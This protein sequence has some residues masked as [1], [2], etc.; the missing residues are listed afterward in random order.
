AYEALPEVAEAW[1]VDICKMHALPNDPAL[2]GGQQWYLRNTVL[3][4]KDIRAVGGWAETVGDSNKVIAIVDSGVDW[5]HPDLG[6]SGPDYVNG[7]VWTNWTEYHGSPSVDDDGNGRVDDIR[8][9]DFV[10]VPG[11]GYPDED[12]DTPDNDPMDYESHG[13]ACAGIAA[14]ITNNGVGIA[15]ASHGCK[16]MAVR[17]GW[18][19]NGSDIGVVR[20][21]FASSGISY[22]ADNGADIIN[23][24]WGSTSY[25]SWAVDYAIGE[26][27]IIV[28]S[29]GNDNDE[30]ASY[31]SSRTD[32]L[33]VAATDQ[34]DIKADF[35]SYGNWVE[36]SAPGVSMYTTW[37][38]QTTMSH[39][40]SSVQGTSFSSP[41]TCG[42]LGLIWSAYPAWPA[43]SVRTHIRNTADP[44]DDV[45]PTYAGKLG[46]GRINLLKALGDTFQEI[47]D[48]FEYLL[49]A[50]NEAGDGDTIA[51]LA[52][53]ALSGTQTIIAKEVN[54]LGGYAAGYGSRDPVNTP[55]VITANATQ[56]AINF[57]GNVGNLTV[58]DGFRCVGGGGSVF[59]TPFSGRF[60]GG[61]VCNAASPTLINIDITGNSVGSSSQVGGGG[62]IFLNNSTAILQSCLIHGNSGIFGAG[63]FVYRGSPTFEDCEIYDNT[64]I[65]AN[66]SNPPRG[67]GV[68][69]TDGDPTFT[70][71]RISGHDD[72]IEGGGIYAVNLGLTTNLTLAGN[73]IYDNFAKDNGGGIYMNGTFIS[74]LGDEVHDN[75]KTASATFMNGGG[76]Y[77]T[78]TDADL[79]GVMCYANDAHAHGGGGIFNATTVNVSNSL[80]YGNEASIYV[81]GLSLNTVAGGTISGN[82]IAVNNGA[83][84]GGG[85]LYLLNSTAA[86]TNN[87]VAFNT[88]TGSQACGFFVSGGSPTFFCNDSYN[89]DI[90][91]YGGIA[92]QTGVNGNISADPDFC[93][94]PG[95]DFTIDDASPCAPAHSGGCGLI[96]ALAPSG[97]LSG[98][99]VDD[100][101]PQVFEVQDNYPNPFNP[102]TTITFSLPKAS[103]TTVRVFDISGRLVKT[104]I[105]EKL[106]AATHDV[107]WT[108]DDNR[109]RQVAA[110]VYFYQ[111]RSGQDEHTGQMA[112][113][114]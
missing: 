111:V 44:I 99:P 60:G 46:D 110:G 38:D 65:T 50:M 84:S 5:M 21:D 73:D 106:D 30:V 47:P 9:W 80:F 4:N 23:C 49:D 10:H 72:L 39:T 66:I 107:V 12:D 112:L 81:G 83:L 1:A 33:S 69:V 34:S 82:T 31:L 11:Q 28:T 24:S 92:D 71:C 13:T 101:V 109:G 86:V 97:C 75:G 70:G 54:I 104:L 26:G 98:A 43:V 17:V 113:V 37:W 40:Y 63:V 51:L 20:M 48:E 62:G 78:N 74:M 114:K 36:L 57:Q 88:G 19:P 18:L 7:A 8:G 67:G 29:A 77:I 52:S 3:G 103:H 108:G 55:T 6:G 27:A 14:A 41:L 61:I 58:V 22:A 59:S 2:T 45:N 25:L 93:D 94:L 95:Y 35:S 96:G 79:D 85:G 68:Y 32:V 53:V 56:P 90:G 76:F 64:S 91:N 102:A 16:V 42:A 100:T 105:Q 89:N 87:I 15:G